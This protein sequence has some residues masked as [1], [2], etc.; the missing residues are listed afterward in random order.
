METVNIIMGLLK[1]SG[2]S[3]KK[4]AGDLGLSEHRVSE[5]KRGKSSSYN[6]YLP[7]IAEYFN[8][9]TDYLLGKEPPTDTIVVSDKQL[10]FALFGDV[11]IDDEVLEDVKAIAKLHAERKA[12]R[13]K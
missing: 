4:F 11:D 10:K 9:T 5:W 1:S 8:V 3:Q 13:T 6:S 2:V 7:Q 12:K